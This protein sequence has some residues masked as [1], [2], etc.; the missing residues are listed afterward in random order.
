M[1]TL[2][3]VLI[4]QGDF[5]L[6]ADLTIP[7]GAQVAVIG[8][9]G[10]GKSTLLATIAGFVTPSAGR[11]TWDGGDMAALAPGDRPI[12]IL[13]QDNNLFPHLSVRQN[14]ALGLR[15]D[16]RLTTTQEAQVDH[17]LA[18][19]RLAQH[20]DHKP[21]RLSGGQIARVALARVLL[22]A[23]P[24]ILLDE[25]FAA[26]GPALKAEMLQM[27]AELAQDTGV[28]LLMVS[29]AP[30]DAKLIADQVVLVA[31]GRA[32]PP[33]ATD[34]LFANPPAALKDYLGG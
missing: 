21:G 13:F 5:S 34:A 26:L 11:V 6:C 14:V 20:A 33:V 31:D 19:V 30:E 25:P 7:A 12:S 8:P 15:P 29:H 22:R 17:A 18:R 3:D 28:T 24:L 32:N 16:L 1:L 4:E 9:S 10:G 27:V 2:E 23:K